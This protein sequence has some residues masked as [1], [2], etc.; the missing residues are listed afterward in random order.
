MRGKKQ[1]QHQ[2]NKEMMI[3]VERRALPGKKSGE[4]D[5]EEKRKQNE[6]ERKEEKGTN[7]C[8]E[9]IF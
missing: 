4:I 6:G 8:N 2:R 9:R 7:A 1:Q 3:E 5:C